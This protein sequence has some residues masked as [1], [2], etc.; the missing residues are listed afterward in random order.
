MSLLKEQLRLT[1]RLTYTG[2]RFISR[3]ELDG[4]AVDAGEGAV[5]I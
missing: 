3:V 1:E 2:T 4:G 5:A